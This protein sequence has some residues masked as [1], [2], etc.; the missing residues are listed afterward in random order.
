M[1]HRITDIPIVVNALI[2]FSCPSPAD[3]R[4]DFFHGGRKGAPPLSDACNAR[5]PFLA[6]V[7]RLLLADQQRSMPHTHRVYGI[8]EAGLVRFIVQALG[9]V[10]LGAGAVLRDWRNADGEARDVP[11]LV[12]RVLSARHAAHCRAAT[13]APCYAAT[14]TTDRVDELLERMHHMYA[15]GEQASGLAFARPSQERFNC[16]RA[17]FDAAT[18]LEA[19]WL[20]RI[21]FRNLEIEY[22][23]ALT[24]CA[25]LDDGVRWHA[26]VSR[27]EKM[28]H[29][30]QLIIH[31]TL[32]LQSLSLRATCQLGHR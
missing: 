27:C 9:L 17:L 10:D 29:F 5:S 1:Q 26:L 11:R 28:L 3:R 31:K 23:G 8:K 25:A 15:D 12:E 14:L 21:L 2:A 13:H 20:C 32:E 16:V 22:V 30:V 24:F 19:K 4:A 18:P 7:L 6:P